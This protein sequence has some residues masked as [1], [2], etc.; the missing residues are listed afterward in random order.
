VTDHDPGGAK[1]VAAI[2]MGSGPDVGENLSRA[3]ELLAA[4]AA[5]GAELVVLPENFAC[6]P[7]RD[8]DRLRIAEDD[9]AGPIQDFLCR[10]SRELGLWIVGGTLPIR[11]AADTRPAAACL[12]F[13]AE[14]QRRARYDKIH[15]FD[16]A[17]PDREESYR[18]SDTI[19]PGESIVV[20]DSPV[21]R[22]GLAV[23][24]DLRFPELFRRMLDRGME[25]VSLPAAFTAHTGRAHWQTLLQ[26]R[27]IENLCWVVAAAQGGRHPNGRETW[28]DSMIVEPWGTVM[29]RRRSGAGI[30][31]ADIDLE[32]QARVR[33]QF[34][35][36]NHR[37]EY[38]S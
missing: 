31:V 29:D 28:G 37:K 30:V 6:M 4:S 16:V 8:T 20:L 24:Y 17:L 9:G 10:S 11:C 5:A 18:E 7:D 2:Q 3:A 12:V 22:L 38:R 34:P 19:Q 32:R 36:L 25:V 35:V 21:G 33:R 15:M 1:R 23:C 14:G 13:D 27:A 26:A